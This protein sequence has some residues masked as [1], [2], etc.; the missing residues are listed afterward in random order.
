MALKVLL[1]GDAATDTAFDAIVADYPQSTLVGLRSDRDTIART[2]NSYPG[3]P[4]ATIKLEPLVGSY[5]HFKAGLKANFG[6]GYVKMEL[7]GPQFDE[8]WRPN[9]TSLVQHTV[10]G[11]GSSHLAVDEAVSNAD[12]DYIKASS[13][14]AANFLDRW[15]F[16]DP[17]AWRAGTIGAVRV[18]VTSRHANTDAAM[19]ANLT[20]YVRIGGTDYFGNTFAAGAAYAETIYSWGVNPATSSAWLWS[21]LAAAEFGVKSSVTGNLGVASEI[22]H[23]Q[24]WLTVAYTPVDFMELSTAS[25]TTATVKG[26]FSA[27]AQNNHDSQGGICSLNIYLKN[28][29][30]NTTT[31]EGFV[32][33]CGTSSADGDYM[34]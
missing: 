9:A 3:T 28:S 30:V 11:A 5:I 32:V 17:E 4:N 7:V 19:V 33:I 27:L 20:P 16:A 6:T 15:G 13:V 14:G 22:R 12:T 8:P 34:S 10:V 1:S 23:T 31:L 25:T 29:G 24:A 2:A 21:D 26:T 18:H